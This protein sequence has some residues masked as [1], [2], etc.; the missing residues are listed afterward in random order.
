MDLGRLRALRELASRQTMSAVAEALF[1]TP[2]AVSQQIAQLEEEVGAKLVE[3]RGRGVCLT[4][5]GEALV[6]HTERILT[7]LDEARSELAEI[8]QVISGVLRVGAFP[9]VASALLP[10]AIN[11]LSTKYPYLEVIVREMEPAEGLAALRAWQADIAFVDDLS[12][13]LASAPDVIELVPV[14]DDVLYAMVPK[15]HRLGTRTSV[16]ISDLRDEKWAL[17]S[18]SSF[19][20]QFLVNLCKRS[21]YEPRIAAECRGFELVWAMVRSGCAVTVVPGLRLAHPL[22]E[23]VVSVK[24][25]PEIG[26]KISVAYRKG[27]RTHPA[28]RVFIEELVRAA[29]GLH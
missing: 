29:S 5:A 8:G 24:L 1:L 9:T 6:G 26:R 4:Q 18:A 28:L 19:Y 23:D 10:Q 13:K 17:D 22:G 21:G 27:E 14:L 15:G 16:S 11:S 25:R 7:I 2:S 3:R 20:A 12:L